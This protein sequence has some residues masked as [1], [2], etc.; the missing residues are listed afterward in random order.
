LARGQSPIGPGDDGWHSALSHWAT[1]VAYIATNTANRLG[2]SVTLQQVEDGYHA[3]P[4]FPVGWLDEPLWPGQPAT[5][6][7]AS[8]YLARQAKQQRQLDH[9]A[10]GLGVPPVRRKRDVFPLMVAAGIL[11]RDGADAYRAGRPARI[12]TVLSLPP[13]QAET[14]RRRDMSS[15]YGAVAQDL[16][17]VLRWTPRPTLEVTAAELAE[18]LLVT[19]KELA[20]ALA[21]AEEVGLLHAEGERPLRL[22]LGPRG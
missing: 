19:D 7:A 11:A 6:P 5:G 14:V 10:A 15:R 20:G 4:L 1:Q 9:I 16:E 2:T 13:D 18:R 12:D 3:P 21:H 22:R 8:A 17:A